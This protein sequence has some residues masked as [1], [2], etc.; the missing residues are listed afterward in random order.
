MASRHPVAAGN[1]AFP[2]NKSLRI[3]NCLEHRLPAV[4]TAN[5]FHRSS[6]QGLFATIFTQARADN[7]NQKRLMRDRV[8]RP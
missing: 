4:A 3:K 7:V 5:C 2:H 8:A 1:I 6:G